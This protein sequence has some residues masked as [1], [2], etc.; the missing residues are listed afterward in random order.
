MPNRAYKNGGELERAAK[1]H[2]EANGYYVIKSAG[3]K[4]AVDLAAIKPGEILFV[5]CKLTGYLGPAE[6]VKFT[7]IAREYLGVPLVAS[8]RKIGT[9]ARFVAF[10]ELIGHPGSTEF[11]PWTPDHGLEST[12]G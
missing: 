9:A 12:A 5:Q 8:W 11:R 7:Q 2:L 1:K 4:G 10:E 6:R 3:S